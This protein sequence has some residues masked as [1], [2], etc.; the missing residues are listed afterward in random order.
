M[1]QNYTLTRKQ[2]LKDPKAYTYT[3]TSSEG[4][5]ISQRKSMRDYAACTID[6][7]YYFGR[8]DLIGKGEH[9]AYLKHCARNGKEPMAIAYLAE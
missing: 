3:V 4:T 1:T 2:N 6:G 5:V 9:G 8:V 7:T